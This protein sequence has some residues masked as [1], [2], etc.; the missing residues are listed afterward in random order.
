MKSKFQM[1]ESLKEVVTGFEGVVMV[2][3]FYFTG[4]VHYGLLPR[5]LSKEGTERDYQW[6]DESRLVRSGAKAVAFNRAEEVRS[7]PMPAAPKIG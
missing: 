5:K 2:I 6:Y 1:G 3:S 4:C 7:G